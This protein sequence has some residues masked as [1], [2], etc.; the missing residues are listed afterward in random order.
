MNISVWLETL[1]AMISK[2]IFNI[3]RYSKYD[4]KKSKIESWNNTKKWRNKWKEER[5][6]RRKEKWVLEGKHPVCNPL[7]NSV[8]SPFR[9]FSEPNHFSP[10]NSCRA[11][12]SPL[13]LTWTSLISTLD[14]RTP[15]LFLSNYKVLSRS[16]HIPSLFKALQ[17]FSSLLRVIAK[18]FKT[19]YRILSNYP[20]YYSPPDP[21][22]FTP[23]TLAFLEHTQEMILPQD[24]CT[25]RCHSQSLSSS[26]IHL[27]DS[28]NSF[29]YHLISET[30][31]DHST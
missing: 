17:C 30:H 18:V 12:L 23:A 7:G 4:L 31:S 24:L 6:E 14:S 29:K 21:I 1:K 20:C 19:A 5:R 2:K 22:Y 25:G 15:S 28:L 13:P 8:C 10:F 16:D 9:R 3:D 26:D 27:T 11:G